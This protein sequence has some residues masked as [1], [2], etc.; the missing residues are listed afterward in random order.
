MKRW[1]FGLIALILAGCTGAAAGLPGKPPASGESADST[2]LPAPQPAPAQPQIDLENLG[3][4]P[5]LENEVWLN[6]EQPLR[7]ADLRGQVV[8]LE[9]WTFGCINC[10]NVIPSVRSWYEAYGPEGLV[11]I[12]NHYPEFDYEA[13]LDNLKEAIE[14]LDVPYPVAQDNE[15]QTWRAYENR[16]WPA[17]YLIDKRGDI[18]YRHFGE[19]MYEVTEAAIQT[20]LAEPYP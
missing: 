6:T 9:M 14:R 20:L 15:G 18:R 3:P 2:D 4:A 13:D 5:E 1:I 11:V 12:G 16:Y 8:L 7:L 19:G 17:L 10:Q